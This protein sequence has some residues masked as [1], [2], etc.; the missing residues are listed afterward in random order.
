MRR[1]AAIRA[2]GFPLAAYT[3]NDPT[4]ARLLYSW[5]VTSVFS[6]APDIILKGGA[7]RASPMPPIA[8]THIPAAMQQGATG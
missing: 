8:A 2:A 4:R 5:G 7:V 6:D 3:V 1:V